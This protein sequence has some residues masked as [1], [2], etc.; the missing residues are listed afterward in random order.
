MPG[1][2]R[3][4]ESQRARSAS[5]WGVR[6]AASRRACHEAARH[7]VGDPLRAAESLP[8]TG[9]RGSHQQSD[10]MPSAGKRS[11]T[12]GCCM[13][14]LCKALHNGQNRSVTRSGQSGA[15][16]GNN[17]PSAGL[18]LSEPRSLLVESPAP[19]K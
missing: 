18:A 17:L 19:P 4:H 13:W 15:D 14:P 3:R 10:I 16:E 2:I 11:V 7:C 8:V 1:G 6:F 12:N 5:G 9:W